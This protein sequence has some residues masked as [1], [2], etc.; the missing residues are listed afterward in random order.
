[1]QI[2]QFLKSHKTMFA[3][4]GASLA[5]AATHLAGL[6]PPPYDAVLTAVAIGLAALSGGPRPASSATP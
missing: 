3:A 4:L 2:I 5:V 1:M 6:V